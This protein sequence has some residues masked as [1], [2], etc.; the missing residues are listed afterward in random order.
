MGGISQ[1]WPLQSSLG[2]GVFFLFAQI[3]SRRL[4]NAFNYL[5]LFLKFCFCFCCF[6]GVGGGED[7][8]RE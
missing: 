3:L 2:L 4:A 6:I 8:E 5:R 1:E 7:R